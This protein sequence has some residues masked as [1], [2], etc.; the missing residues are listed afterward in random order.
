MN[1]K[2]ETYTLGAFRRI[3]DAVKSGEYDKAI[4]ICT[5]GISY[6]ESLSAN[7][8]INSASDDEVNIF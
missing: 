6:V 7:A 3:R 4:Q 5:Y 1:N 8:E 2:L